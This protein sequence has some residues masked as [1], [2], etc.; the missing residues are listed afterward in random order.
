M[1][2]FSVP[3]TN[4][5]LRSD[6]VRCATKGCGGHSIQNPFFAH[7]KVSQFTVAFCI[8]KNIV[9]FQVPEIK[10]PKIKSTLKSWWRSLELPHELQNMTNR[11]F[12]K[13]RWETIFHMRPWVP[14]KRHYF[15]VDSQG[16]LAIQN[17][18]S[19][20]RDEEERSHLWNCLQFKPA[21]K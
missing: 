10:R 3:C 21:Q 9:Q 13:H 18:D 11:W 19:S 12:H 17:S 20:E 6:I 5:Y 16:P 15:E 4:P 14:S 8:Q 1:S 7:P 2:V